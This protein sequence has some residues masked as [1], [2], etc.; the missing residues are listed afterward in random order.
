MAKQFPGITPAQQ[1]FI[2]RQKVFFTASAAATGRVNVSP[3]GTD[4]LRVLGPNAVVYLDLTG[5]GNETAAHLRATGRLT[6]MLCA[7]E[8]APMILR[9]YGAGRVLRRGG[10]DYARLL[11]AEFGDAE[12]LGARQMV[13]LDIDLVQT[14]CGFGVPL[15]DHAGERPT[16]ARWAEAKEAQEGLEAYR[17]QKNT[18]SID[19]LPTGLFED[20][21]VPAG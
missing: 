3:R 17:R 4:M 7:F 6:I 1:E 21:P 19:G 13:R 15:F 2:R 20:D 11:A 18:R 12:P 5:S 9:L 10:P 14:S 8:G 16:L